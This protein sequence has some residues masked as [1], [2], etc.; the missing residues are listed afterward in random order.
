MTI[1]F[2]D[3]LIPQLGEG[4]RE[5]RIVRLLK[6]EGDVVRKDEPLLEIET[7]KAQAQIESAYEG[8][9]RRWLAN[10][11]DVLAVGA[12]VAQL[13][14]AGQPPLPAQQGRGGGP[15]IPPRTRAHCR[16]LGISGEEM[17]QIPAPSGKLMPADVDAWVAARRGAELRPAAPASPASPASPGGAGAVERPSPRS[18]ARSTTA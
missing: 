2:V 16:A 4:L 13:E 15:L 7:D 5:V 8:T 10:E 17:A 3:V 12:A 14:V 11:D 6:Q 1:L 9:L 18:S